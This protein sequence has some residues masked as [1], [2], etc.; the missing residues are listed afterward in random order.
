MLLRIMRTCKLSPSPGV[1]KTRL[2]IIT[3]FF[4]SFF[5]HMFAMMN[6][7]IIFIDS[8]FNFD[9]VHKI[10]IDLLVGFVGKGWRGRVFFF[11]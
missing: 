7:C 8:D 6:M 3:L 4:S 10:P 9:R 1:A 2:I 5:L 11:L